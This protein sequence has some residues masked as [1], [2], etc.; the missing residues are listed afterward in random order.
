MRRLFTSADS[1]LS[2]GELAWGVRSGRCVRLQQGIYAEGCEPTTPLDRARAK[3]LASKREAR[4]GLAGVLLGLDSVI[5]DDRPTRRAALPPERIVIA[6]DMRCADGPQTMI[7]LAPSLD[8]DTWEQALE[9]ALRKKLV[10]ID[11]LSAVQSWTPGAPRI[12]RVLAARPAGAPPTESLLET[13]ALQLA[14]PI[15]GEPVRQL[16]VC[17]AHGTFIARVDLTW[18]DREIFFELDGQGHKDQPVYDAMRETA[19]VA[20]TGWLPGRF[21]WSEIT[22][23]PVS[24]QRRFA[25]LRAQSDRRRAA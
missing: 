7:D 4:G 25:E 16:V 15:L 11:A 12:R 5:L 20:A 22:R 13:L 2:R 24:T 3:V 9:S 6:H 10:T 14:R 17:S 18:P 1:G 8:D 19:V 21:T 23:I